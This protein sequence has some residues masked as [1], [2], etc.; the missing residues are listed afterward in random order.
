MDRLPEVTPSSGLPLVL[1]GATV[2]RPSAT[3]SSSAAIWASAV[4]TPWPYST[5]PEKTVT[6]SAGESISQED[7]TGL[8]ARLGIA[9]RL[10]G[11][12][13]APAGGVPAP[14]GGVPAPGGD[15]VPGRAVVT[16]RPARCRGAWRP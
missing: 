15:L 12:V 7:R 2:T 10:A 16:G 6:V 14:A 3:S 13:P 9:A 8:A 4:Q 5:L 1:T 11:G